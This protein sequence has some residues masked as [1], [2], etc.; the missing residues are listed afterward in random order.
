MANTRIFTLKTFILTDYFYETVGL[1]IDIE[2]EPFLIEY[3]VTEDQSMFSPSLYEGIEIISISHNGKEI[4]MISSHFAEVEIKLYDEM[5][6]HS[7]QLIA[8]QNQNN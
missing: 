5:I 4:E 1:E 7:Y 3:E 6:E 2:N 8:E